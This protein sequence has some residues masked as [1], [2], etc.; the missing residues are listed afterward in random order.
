MMSYEPSL[1]AY[2]DVLN[3]LA[4][5]VKTLKRQSFATVEHSD[6]VKTDSEN[7]LVSGRNISL[8][9][10]VRTLSDVTSQGKLLTEA[11]YLTW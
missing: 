6:L 4:L 8:W 5:N 10:L 1:G 7:I 9:E 11:T 2:L 3:D